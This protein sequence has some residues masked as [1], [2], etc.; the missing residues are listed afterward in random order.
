MRLL[1]RR[2]ESGYV[3]SIVEVCAKVVHPADWEEDVYA[4]LEYLQVAALELAEDERH[5][6]FDSFSFYLFYLS[7]G[8]G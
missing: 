7:A 2:P 3:E 4:E 6:E 1:F 8:E 5:G